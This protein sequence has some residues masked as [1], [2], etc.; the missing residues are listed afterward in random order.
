M[1]EIIG[2]Q[3]GFEGTAVLSTFIVMT[4]EL[5]VKFYRVED[6]VKQITRQI[7]FA[8][9]LVAPFK[10]QNMIVRG[11]ILRSGGKSKYMIYIDLIGI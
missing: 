2:M 7:L 6:Y 1:C 4:S 8:Y 11:G 5:Y 3:Y 10:I 9:A